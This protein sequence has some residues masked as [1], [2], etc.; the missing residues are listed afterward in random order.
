MGN[1]AEEFILTA[2]AEIFPSATGFCLPPTSFFL[3]NFAC[4][5]SALHDRFLNPVKKD[6][7]KECKIF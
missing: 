6:I 3:P 1:I 5:L 7:E 2:Q 4:H